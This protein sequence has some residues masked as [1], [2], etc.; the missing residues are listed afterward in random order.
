MDEIWKDIKGYEGLYQ[1]SDQGNV[2]SLYKRHSGKEI[3]K[4]YTNSGYKYVSLHKEKKIKKHRVHRLVAEAF[5]ENHEN[6]EQVNHINGI[7]TDN[8]AINL[9]WCTQSENMKHAYK[10]GLQKPNTEKAHEAKRKL[11]KNQVAEIK[12]LLDQGISTRAIAKRFGVGKTLIS[13]I[14]LGKA[15]GYA[16]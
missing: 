10:I 12:A 11:N 14:K 8:R 15:R 9:E 2:K 1:I 5:L 16:T 13:S 3:M 6:K 4:Q 7:K